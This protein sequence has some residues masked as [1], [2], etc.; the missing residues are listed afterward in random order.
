MITLDLCANKLFQGVF[1]NCYNQLDSFT[2]KPAHHEFDTG[3][4]VDI[5]AS[6]LPLVGVT[7]FVVFIHRSQCWGSW[8]KQKKIRNWLGFLRNLPLENIHVTRFCRACMVNKVLFWDLPKWI[9][10][11]QVNYTVLCS[12]HRHHKWKSTHMESR[13]KLINKQLWPIFESESLIHPIKLI[14]NP[15]N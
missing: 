4:C 2:V 8:P 12:F 1:F 9:F 3:R 14:F 11:L 6:L 13:K 15:L 10:P 5:T 7:S